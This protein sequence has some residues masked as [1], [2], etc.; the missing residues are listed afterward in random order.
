MRQRKAEFYEVYYDYMERMKTNQESLT[1]EEVFLFIKQETGRCESS[2]SSKLLATLNP[3]KPVWDKFVL[4]NLGI[5]KIY[6]GDSNR[7]Q[8]TIEAYNQIC[9]WYENFM[10]SDNAKLII[11]IFDEL[12]PNTMITD[13]KKVD[14]FLWQ[15]REK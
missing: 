9:Q 5:K 12:Y 13:T 2:F 4:E 15:H 7:E 11:G 14:L 6:S 1:F 8:K 3:N 10:K